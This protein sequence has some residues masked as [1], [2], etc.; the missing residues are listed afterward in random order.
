MLPQGIITTEKELTSAVEYFLT[1]SEF[2]FDIEGPHDRTKVT[3][4]SSTSNL[5]VISNKMVVL[6]QSLWGM[7]GE[8]SVMKRRFLLRINQVRT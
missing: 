6:L 2:Y 4:P 3:A 5:V 8:N 1:Q 7:R